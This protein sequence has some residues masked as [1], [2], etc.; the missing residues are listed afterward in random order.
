MRD[1]TYMQMIR[2]NEEGL[3]PIFI[4]V[5][6]HET[7]SVSANALLPFTHL[8]LDASY[9]SPRIHSFSKPAHISDT[10]HTEMWEVRKELFEMSPKVIARA[11]N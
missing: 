10:D 3:F 7:N 1:G 4:P 8:T 6:V 5:S 2:N 11:G 9:L